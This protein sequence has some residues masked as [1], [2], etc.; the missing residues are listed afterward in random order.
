[1]EPGLVLHPEVDITDNDFFNSGVPRIA[2][3][4]QQNHATNKAMFEAGSR[5]DDRAT[6]R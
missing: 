1:M 5:T 2:V 3:S 6:N 4:S